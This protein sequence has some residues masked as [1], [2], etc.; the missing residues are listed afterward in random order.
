MTRPETVAL[1]VPCYVDQLHPEV[2]WATLRLLERLG[3]RVEVPPDQTCC[4]QPLLNAGFHDGAAQAARHFCKVFA[5]VEHVE[6]V[7]CPS[8]SC[9]AMVRRHYADLQPFEPTFRVYE[10]CE[11]IVDVLKI[12]SL[13]G[14]FPHRVGL[15][16]GCHGLRDLRL[17]PSSERRRG[18]EDGNDGG[19]ASVNDKPASLLASL[20]GITLVDLAR[21]D[22]CCGF[23]GLFSV[24]ESA[25]SVAMGR[26]RFADHLHAGAQVMTSTDMSCLMHLQG[27]I[28]RQRV[29]L[30]VRHIAQVLEEATR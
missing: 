18:D 9:T 3:V 19:D 22:E 10:L 7:V 26:D 25:V 29:P 17:A 24:E 30:E 27:L 4:G 28:Q 13:E 23:G 12:G 2:A 21:R 6:H 5:S 14:R 8:G 20:D 11:F 15:H 16:P 1:F